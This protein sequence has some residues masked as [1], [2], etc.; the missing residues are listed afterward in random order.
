[1]KNFLLYLIHEQPTWA[2]L[3]WMFCALWV[4]GLS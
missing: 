3:T 1:M 4:V 2:Y